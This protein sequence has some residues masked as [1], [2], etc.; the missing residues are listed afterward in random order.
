MISAF[1]AS[2]LTVTVRRQPSVIAAVAFGLAH[3][4]LVRVLSWLALIGGNRLCTGSRATSDWSGKGHVGDDP[5]ELGE[6]TVLDC[7]WLLDR[8]GTV[9]C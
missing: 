9:I 8:A 6:D 4:M 5:A 2:D 3:L 7:S 1:M